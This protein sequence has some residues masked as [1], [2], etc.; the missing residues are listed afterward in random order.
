[1]RKDALPWGLS[2]VLFIV[3]VGLLTPR[4]CLLCR[5]GNPIGF[6]LTTGKN[7]LL[8]SKSDSASKC[9]GSQT[10][11]VQIRYLTYPA[12]LCR[13]TGT[14][15]CSKVGVPR[16]LPTCPNPPPQNGTLCF[17]FQTSGADVSVQSQDLDGTHPDK[18][19]GGPAQATILISPYPI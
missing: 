19:A 10:C 1:M 16:A 2:G 13:S 6:D 3:I 18:P 15:D 12:P 9:L 14:S 11:Y 5:D 7:A 17:T 8:T 4:I